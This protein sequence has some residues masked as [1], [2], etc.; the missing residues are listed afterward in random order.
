MFEILGLLTQHDQ[1]SGEPIRLLILANN[2]VQMALLKEV[3]NAVI[4]GIHCVYSPMKCLPA[5]HTPSP[6]D[7]ANLRVGFSPQNQRY[8]QLQ[9]SFSGPDPIHYHEYIYD[10]MTTPHHMSQ[11]AQD[12]GQSMPDPFL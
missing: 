12:F 9:P 11:Q 4:S 1:K 3:S 6:C 7:S 5:E 2:M 10:H 8:F